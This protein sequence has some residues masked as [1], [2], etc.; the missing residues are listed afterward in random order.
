M[1][2][3]SSSTMPPVAR[4]LVDCQPDA[5]LSIAL[6]HKSIRHSDVLLLARGRGR[7]GGRSP[8]RRPTDCGIRKVSP[9]TRIIH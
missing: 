8:I 9:N 7:V 3:G 4:S 2:P 1:K 6:R 5:A